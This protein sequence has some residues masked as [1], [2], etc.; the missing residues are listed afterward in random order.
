[1]ASDRLPDLAAGMIVI[2]LGMI[3]E[4]KHLFVV[5]VK[6]PFPCFGLKI[7]FRHG[8]DDE[9]IN[10]SRKPAGN[11]VARPCDVLPDVKRHFD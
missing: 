6:R 7:M 5:Q 9:L 3:G 4:E 1:M 11:P 2:R 8:G 10:R